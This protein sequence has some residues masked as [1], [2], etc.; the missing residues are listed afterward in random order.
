MDLR[1]K[2]KRMI[3]EYPNI[4]ED[5]QLFRKVV[6]DLFS[7]NKLY[8]NLLIIS[9]EERIPHYILTQEMILD[10]FRDHVLCDFLIK[11]SGC[12]YELAKEI[13]MAWVFALGVKYYYH[14]GN[15]SYIISGSTLIYYD[16]YSPASKVVVPKG[17]TEIA[18]KAF[19]KMPIKEVVLPEGIRII[20]EQAF[21]ECS[22]LQKITLP[23]GLIS[24]GFFAFYKCSSL[25]S[26]VIPDSVIWF[27][28]ILCCCDSLKEI[29]MNIDRIDEL[30]KLSIPSPCRVKSN[31]RTEGDFIVS[32]STLIRYTGTEELEPVIVPEGIKYVGNHAFA[33][34]CVTE[35]ILPEGVETIGDCA[36][37]SC[38]SLKKVV[39]PHS[40]QSI[41]SEAFSDCCK[42]LSPDIPNNVKRIDEKAFEYCRSL[43]E[44]TLGTHLLIKSCD[45]GLGPACQVKCNVPIEGDFFINRKTLVRY[46]PN[47]SASVITIPDRI[48][49]IAKQAF[50][51]SRITEVILPEGITTIDDEAFYGC[52]DLVKVI[53]PN[54]LKK[55]GFRAFAYCES[56]TEIYIPDSVTRIGSFA[57]S[58]CDSL[59]KISMTARLKRRLLKEVLYSFE[60]TEIYYVRNTNG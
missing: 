13:V 23:E 41:R 22:M 7:E 17:I 16:G 48:K 21:A 3:K 40:L 30:D 18:E 35:V 59:S 58:G 5:E 57:F 54:S 15:A 42:L 6:G 50:C 51:G 27:N 26:M 52:K 47:Q 31:K 4:W 53:L 20:G 55:I 46:I 56:L 10:L 29:S 44:I 1:Y 8:K 33:Y 37:K 32:N 28:S 2:L 38:H 36:F 45:F 49:R 34:S 9:V 25:T 60:N 12:S 24:I 11:A 19:Y 14:E 43:T 39:L